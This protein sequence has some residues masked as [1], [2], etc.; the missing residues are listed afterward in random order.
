VRPFAAGRELAPAY[1]F[2][3]HLARNVIAESGRA[4]II[5]LSLARAPGPMK[6]GIGTWCYMAR[7]GYWR[8]EA[9]RVWAIAG[10]LYEA[11]TGLAPFDQDDDAGVEYPSCD[12]PSVAQL[13]AAREQAAGLPCGE[14]RFAGAV[15]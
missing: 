13:G 1:E 5:D 10:V 7:K 6:P 11:V 3:A 14:R 15:V 4:K 12:R 8:R 2:I 9:V